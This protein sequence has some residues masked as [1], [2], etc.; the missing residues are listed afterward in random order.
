MRE[1][2]TVS[3]CQSEEM[4]EELTVSCCQPEE[5]REELTV[6][7]SQSEEM[8]EEL[9][10]SCSHPGEMR[11]ELT[12]SCSQSEDGDLLCPVQ[13]VDVIFFW[14]YLLVLLPQQTTKNALSQ[15]SQRML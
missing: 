9:T 1:E 14:P 12:V 11:E 7:C 3:C 10:V 5:M 2:L 8:R 15:R 6:S 13:L 4:R